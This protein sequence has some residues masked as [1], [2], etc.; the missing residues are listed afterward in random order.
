MSGLRTFPGRADAQLELRA[1]VH[2]RAKAPTILD[3]AVEAGVSKSAVSRALLGQGEVSEGVRER[4]EG[5]AAKLGYVANAMARGLV[6]AR[7]RTIGA[8]LRDMTRPFYGELFAGMQLGAETRGY[9]VVTVTSTGDLEVADA[10]RT[11]KS[12]ISMQ[13]DGLVIASA[14]LPSEQIV[15]FI[16]RVPIVVA[17]RAETS[18]GIT[19]VFSDDD[20]GGRA[21]ARHVLALGHARIAVLLVDRAYSLSQHGRGEAMVE[22]IRDAGY[23][24]VVWRIGTDADAAAAVAARLGSAAVDVIM[25]PTDGA[26]I[27]VMEVLRQLGRST[28]EDMSV[29]GYDGIGPLAAPFFGLTTLRVPVKEI[30]RMSMELLIDRIEGAAQGDRLVALKGQ[31]VEGRTAQ[32]SAES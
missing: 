32:A 2:K 9:Q 10:L 23:S 11:L 24:P 29:T 7:T 15:P 1:V 13:V 22:Q 26:A 25:C 28:P 31:L 16:D 5:A 6:S 30:G 20:F 14:R 8:V 21:I 19:S 12:L 27:D 18:P 3:I 17:G 4:V